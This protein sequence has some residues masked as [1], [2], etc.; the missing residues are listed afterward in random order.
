MEKIKTL[1]VFI[2]VS[3]I[4]GA[5]I[6][7]VKYFAPSV[8]LLKAG[9]PVLEGPD[10]SIEGMH[11]T[12]IKGSHREV[13]AFADSALVSRKGR[14]AALINVKGSIFR[15]P[16]G[17]LYFSSASGKVNMDNGSSTAGGGVTVV[18]DDGYSIE[19]D[20]MNY[21]GGTKVARTDGN[22]KFTGPA[23]SGMGRGVTVDTQTQAL[24]ILSGVDVRL[25]GRGEDK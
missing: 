22:F 14:T 17:R 20:E 3:F 12:K 16:E 6:Y 11:Y 4:A 8:E 7:M 23:V 10:I 15:E 13:E 2:L 5:S 21:D 19:T 18:T 24:S 1:M 9:A 25:M